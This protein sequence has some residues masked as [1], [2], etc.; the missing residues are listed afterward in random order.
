[1]DKM[2][3]CLIF[4]YDLFFQYLHLM[5]ESKDSLAAFHRSASQCHGVLGTTQPPT[6][7]IL[8]SA[9]NAFARLLDLK[10]SGNFQCPVCGCSPETPSKVEAILQAPT[11]RNV[12]ELRSFLW[13][14]NYYGKFIPN[15]SSI[16]HPLTN[17]LR[18]GQKWKWTKQC[19]KAF[20]EA[21]ERLSTA[22]VLAHYDSATK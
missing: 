15:L 8:C 6:L 2:T 4:I 18:A 21:K 19:A 17:L 5:I 14:I 10:F 12:T 13:M 11:P 7:K 9:W 1:M 20:Q 22:E 16:N 3:S